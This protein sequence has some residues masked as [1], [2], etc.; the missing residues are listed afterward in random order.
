MAKSKVLKSLAEEEVRPSMTQENLVKL[1]N[2]IPAMFRGQVAYTEA[3][4]E[5][6]AAALEEVSNG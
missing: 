5:I 4:P 3:T 2:K 1:L 6:A